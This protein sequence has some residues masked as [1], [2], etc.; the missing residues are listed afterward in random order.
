MNLRV[1]VLLKQTFVQLASKRTWLAVLA[2][3]ACLL[4]VAASALPQGIATGTI[5]GTVTDP[6]GAAVAAAKVTSVNAATNQTIVAETNDAGIFSQRSVPPGIYKVTVEAKGFRTVVLD[7][8]QVTVAQETALAPV[9]L[10]LGSLG[11]TIQVEGATPLIETST[12]Q[13]TTNFDSVAT[14]D[15][16]L[17]GG[18]DMLTLFIP[19][20]ADTGSNNFSNTNGVGFSANGLRGR[21][22]N[23]QIDG[24]SNNDN[25]EVVGAAA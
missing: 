16:P 13:V 3:A 8:V 21:S 15:L 23:F 14:A 7:K 10:E 24:Q 18:Y 5:S 2:S 1:N 12:A 9:K 19:G 22:N 25:S 20:V 4:L 11:E 6:S 17:N